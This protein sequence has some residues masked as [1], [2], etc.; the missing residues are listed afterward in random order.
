MT[1]TTEQKAARLALIKQVAA[2]RKAAAEFKRRQQINAAKVRRYTDVV[3]RPARS[4]KSAEFDR[5]IEKMNEN[6]NQ[7]TD[8]PQYAEKYYG[9][10][11]RDTTR[12]DNEWN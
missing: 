11:Y 4:A 10:V 3:D 1:M 9:Q 12:F 8:A 5:A 2:K 6:H 7:W